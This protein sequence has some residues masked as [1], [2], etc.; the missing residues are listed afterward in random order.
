VVKHRTYF[1]DDDDLISAGSIGLMKAIL[2]FDVSKNPI[3]NIYSS[4]SIKKAYSE[5]RKNIYLEDFGGKKLYHE[6]RNLID[7]KPVYYTY[8]KHEMYNELHEAMNTCLTSVEREVIMLKH[9]F[10]GKRYTGEEIGKMLGFSQKNA[11]LIYN[12]TYVKLR[13]NINKKYKMDHTSYT[14]S[15]KY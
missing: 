13:N 2:T 6:Y 7:E 9:G 11:S 8:L 12:R 5:V 1:T 4:T 15:I 3:F 10:Y 14:K